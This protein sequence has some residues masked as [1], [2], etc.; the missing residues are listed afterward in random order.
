MTSP[1]I[2]QILDAPVPGVLAVSEAQ[3]G[4]GLLLLHAW[5]GLNEFFKDLTKRL[6]GEGFVTLT[7]DLYHGQIAKTIETAEVL[8]ETLDQRN[9]ER[10]LQGAVE[11]LQSHPATSG[12]KI[13][14]IGFSMGAYF[15]MNLARTHP[16]DIGAVVV[17]Y[18]VA[19]GLF[20]DFAIPV[21]GH[22]AENDVYGAGPDEVQD[23]KTRLAAGQ[24]IIDFHE[25]PETSHWFFEEDVKDAYNADAAS[26]AYKRMLVFL[27]EWLK[28]T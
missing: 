6:A 11:F 16:S 2:L 1:V 26:L 20:R 19:G 27:R 8:S 14:L 13:G 21:Q 4:P 3:S 23:L 18:D 17:Y 28:K 12:D 7:P 24:G 10:L 5:W 9:T 22:F 15:A 25:Y